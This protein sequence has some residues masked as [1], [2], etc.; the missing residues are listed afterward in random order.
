MCSS[1]LPT[2]VD[3]IFSGPLPLLDAL[4]ASDI[5][6]TV[7]LNN[8]LPGTY[9]IEPVVVVTSDEI[10]IESILPETIEVMIQSNVP[11]PTP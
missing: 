9:Q 5:Q 4:N 8:Y 11:T 2:T 7:D 10:K 6:V 1:D 3:I